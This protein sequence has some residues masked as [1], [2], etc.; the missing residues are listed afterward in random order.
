MPGQQGQPFV[1]QVS[2]S[3]H[4]RP[5]GQPHNI[6]MQPSQSQGPQFPQPMQQYPPR[7]S[8]SGNGAP[9]SQPM[10]MPY[11]QPNIPP[12]P[13]SSHPQQGGSLSNHVPGIGG[14]GGIP[15]PSSYAVRLI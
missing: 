3:Q 11:V 15:F 2:A 4:F 5:V 10:S 7:S 12:T 14:G 13:A 1:S 6:V 8:Q 9:S